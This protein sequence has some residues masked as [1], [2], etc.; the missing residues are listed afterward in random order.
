MASLHLSNP[1]LSIIPPSRHLVSKIITA[2]R[3]K[4]HSA[5]T[6]RYRTDR[7]IEST[8]ESYVHAP[9]MSFFDF[10]AVKIKSNGRKKYLSEIP[11]SLRTVVV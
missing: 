2:G 5:R 3:N 6:G 8:S 10:P 7:Q 11:D 1:F 4:Q 9:R